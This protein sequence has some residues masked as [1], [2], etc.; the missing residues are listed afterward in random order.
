MVAP[1]M[2]PQLEQGELPAE[3]TP[4]VPTH[5]DFGTAIL[6]QIQLHLGLLPPPQP[7]LPASSTPIALAED[8]M[9]EEASSP[10]EALTT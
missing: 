1:P 2:P 5:I 6:R 10:S 8:T 7:D 4:P 3:T 9:S